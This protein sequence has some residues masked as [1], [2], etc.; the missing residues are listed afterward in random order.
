M[1]AN[2]LSNGTIEEIIRERGNTLLTVVYMTGSGK[3]RREERI[4][5]VIGP[6]TIILNANGSTKTMTGTVIF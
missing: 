4:R 5:L 2:R 1:P 6:R 3:Q